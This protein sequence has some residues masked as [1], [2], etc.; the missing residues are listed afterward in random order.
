[1]VQPHPFLAPPSPHTYFLHFRPSLREWPAPPSQ[2]VVKAPD[3]RMYQ[4]Y[5]LRGQRGDPSIPVVKAGHQE[6][7]VSLGYIRS[8]GLAWVT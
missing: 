8:S 5:F 2:L 6:F 1:M 7:K 3:L 4:K